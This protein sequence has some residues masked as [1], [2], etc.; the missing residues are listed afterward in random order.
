M[1]YFQSSSCD[2]VQVLQLDIELYQDVS[3]WYCG[4]L[5]YI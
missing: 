5:N 4:R 2:L 3:Q 1:I